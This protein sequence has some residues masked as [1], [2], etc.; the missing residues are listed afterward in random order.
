MNQRNDKGLREGYWEVYYPNGKLG[1]F[2][3]Y[4]N[5]IFIGYYEDYN[6][7]GIMIN[8]DFFL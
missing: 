7:D 6:K 8:K 4:K 2:G 1:W 3:T 5:G